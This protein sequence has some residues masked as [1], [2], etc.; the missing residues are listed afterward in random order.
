MLVASSITGTPELQDAVPG[1]GQE[2][3]AE[4]RQDEDPGEQGADGA[5]GAPQQHPESQADRSADEERELP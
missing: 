3:A 4:G 5:R 1:V 2:R